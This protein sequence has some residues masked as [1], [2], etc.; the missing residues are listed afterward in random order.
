MIDK[1]AESAL[2]KL[3]CPVL[4]KVPRLVDPEAVIQMQMMRKRVGFLHREVLSTLLLHLRQHL[5]LPDPA[6]TGVEG[7]DVFS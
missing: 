4:V 5:G 3:E 1:A 2:Q 6:P 7:E